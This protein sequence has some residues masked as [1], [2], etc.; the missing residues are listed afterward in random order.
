MNNFYFRSKEDSGG[1]E[2]TA[3]TVRVNTI[4]RDTVVREFVGFMIASGFGMPRNIFEKIN[5][6]IGD[7][8]RAESNS[9]SRGQ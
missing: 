4:Y 2:E 7:E 5:E 3:V 8:I 1:G 9:D 6:L